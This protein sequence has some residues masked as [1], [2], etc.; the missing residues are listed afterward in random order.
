MEVRRRLKAVEPAVHRRVSTE[1]LEKCPYCGATVFEGDRF[2]RKC[3]HELLRCPNCGA[4][5]LEDDVFCGKCGYKLVEEVFICPV[6]GAE[7]PGDAVICPNCG[8]R[9][10]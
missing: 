2:C 3:G 9:F 1:T 6:C 4:I 7:I 5:V 8:A 10:E